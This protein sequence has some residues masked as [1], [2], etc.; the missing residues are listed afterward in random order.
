MDSEKAFYFLFEDDKLKGAV[1]THVDDFEF[2]STPN[3]INMLIYS[4][5]KKLTISKVGQGKFLFTR[6]DVLKQ[7]YNL[8]RIQIKN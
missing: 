7:N 5:F 8:R 6:L 1:Q 4:V 3:F 2:A